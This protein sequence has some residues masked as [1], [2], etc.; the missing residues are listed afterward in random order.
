MNR[1]RAAAAV[2]AALALCA[3]VQAAI[4]KT[5]DVLNITV[6]QHP[7]FSGR[8]T[9]SDNGTIDYPLLADEVVVNITT[10]ELMSQLTFRLAR[11]VD[12]PLVLVSLIEVPEIMVIVLGQAVKPGPVTTYLNVSL[13]EVLTLAGG[14]APT[15]DLSRVK[16]IAKDDPDSR[17]R[18][19]NLEEFMRSGNMD[20]MPRLRDG[21][22]VVLLSKEKTEKVKVIG[23]VRQPGFFA[24][25][26]KINIFEA[27]YMA[28][29]PAENADLSRV[30]RITAQGDKSVEEVINIQ[31]YIDKGE[32][33]RIPQ[34]QAGDVIIVYTRWFDWRTVLAILNNT[35]LFIVT[36][37]AFSG[38]FSK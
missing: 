5:G 29:G 26:E 27:V 13:Q 15:A 20:G 8:F 35:L 10:S 17:A 30:R 4:I 23:G 7:E 31:G 19:F 37:Q 28:G 12:N 32:M 11:H 3:V 2:L 38:I 14:P 1:H 6:D 22:T 9:V 25:E 34:V 33:N 24:L 16:I 36:I 21:E 18:F